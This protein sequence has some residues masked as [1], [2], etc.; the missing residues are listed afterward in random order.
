MRNISFLAVIACVLIT[1]CSGDSEN[2]KTGNKLKGSISL[3]GA[4]ALYPLAVKWAEEFQKIHPD[5]RID[6]QAGG[7]GKG[8]ADALGNQVNLGMV[9]RDIN[10]AEIKK[11]AWYIPV[12]KDA[13]IPT[14]SSA[15]PFAKELAQKGMSR[16]HFLQLWVEGTPLTWGTVLGTTSTEQIK[17]YKRSDAAGAAESWAKYLGKQQD[18]LKGTGV[19]GD[20]GLANAVKKDLYG[21]GFN[22]VIYVYD[23][24][25]KKPYEGISVIPIDINENG[26]LDADENFY[27]TMEDVNA[28]I[29]AGK[30]PSP[31]AR[32]LYFV[33]NGKPQD[34]I[35]TEFLKWILTDGQKYVKEAG[36]INLSQDKITDAQNKLK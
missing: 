2:T 3:S 1:S 22:N 11:G 35:V 8:M 36:F 6:A 33:S 17:V 27:G 14:Y 4:F 34:V 31:P 13:V 15:N 28:A 9:S 23:L 12:A 16:K 32:D 7:A 10:E 26:T 5:V 24:N 18:D 25:T 30:Y 20:P 21:V 29:A 19:F